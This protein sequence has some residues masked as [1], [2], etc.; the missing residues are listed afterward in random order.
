MK[1]GRDVVRRPLEHSKFIGR[2]FVHGFSIPFD[3]LFQ[4]IADSRLTDIRDSEER[5]G[6]GQR[7]TYAQ[8]GRR[9]SWVV[10]LHLARERQ[11][12]FYELAGNDC[13]SGRQGLQKPRCP[14]KTYRR[15]SLL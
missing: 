3:G 1:V 10:N 7:S 2:R 8:N 11:P 13:F 9:S 12:G 15:N 14:V 5:Q 4:G 6:K